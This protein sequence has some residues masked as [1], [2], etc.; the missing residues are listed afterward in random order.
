MVKEIWPAKFKEIGSWVKELITFCPLLSTPACSKKLPNFAVMH[1][2]FELRP[3]AWHITPGLTHTHSVGGLDVRPSSL[4]KYPQIESGVFLTYHDKYDLAKCGWLI[5]KK[6]LLFLSICKTRVVYGHFKNMADCSNGLV[7][8]YLRLRLDV[9]RLS[10]PL[11][12]MSSI[13]T[14]LTR[15]KSHPILTWNIFE[16]WVRTLLES[17]P[18]FGILSIGPKPCFNRGKTIK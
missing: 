17:G 12:L 18:I 9:Q 14:V 11:G 10:L 15:V 5:Q 4:Y 6:K 2:D 3:W 1:V 13:I 16:I 7:W 8:N